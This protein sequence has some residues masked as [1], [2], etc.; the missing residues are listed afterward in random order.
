LERLLTAGV[1]F[2][3]QFSDNTD[4]VLRPRISKHEMS[5]DASIEPQLNLSTVAF[6]RHLIGR[7]GKVQ[8]VA[9]C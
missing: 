7:M 2:E 5:E 8:A 4:A 3:P 9:I 6:L 1:F